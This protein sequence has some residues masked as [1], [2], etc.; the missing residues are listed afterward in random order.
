MGV[1][2]SAILPE[3]VKGP[4]I[5]AVAADRTGAEGVSLE[6]MPDPCS[7]RGRIEAGGVASLAQFRCS[8]L[9][10]N[11][12]AKAISVDGNVDYL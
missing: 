4:G 2:A 6:A 11:I 9:A 1:R 7:L 10:W 12:A 8:G 5:D 3:A